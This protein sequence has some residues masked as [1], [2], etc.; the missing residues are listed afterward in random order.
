MQSL[1]HYYFVT[2]AKMDAQISQGATPLYK[3][4]RARHEHIT[5]V[6][7]KNSADFIKTL[8]I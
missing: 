8:F 3:A 4:I 7:L 6:L 5:R 1:C 2:G